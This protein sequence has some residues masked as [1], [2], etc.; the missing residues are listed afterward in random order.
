MAA[1]FAY[2]HG[3]VDEHLWN[4]FKANCC[5][6]CVGELFKIKKKLNPSRKIKIIFKILQ[7]VILIFWGGN[8]DIR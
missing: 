4:D 3:F 5:K 8:V 6:G 7:I 1:Q 2:S